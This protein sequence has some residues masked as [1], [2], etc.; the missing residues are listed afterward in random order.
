MSTLVIASNADDYQY[1]REH[2]LLL[3]IKASFN[4]D[5]IIWCDQEDCLKG[6]SQIVDY[7]LYFDSFKHLTYEQVRALAAASLTVDQVY[8]V[9]LKDD[10]LWLYE[11]GVI[12]DCILH[13]NGI[14]AAISKSIAFTNKIVQKGNTVMAIIVAIIFAVLLAS[15]ISATTQ[16]TVYAQPKQE[17]QQIEKEDNAR[18]PLFF[19]E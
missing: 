12:I 16:P 11:D 7:I 10:K 4:A 8:G 6:L 2:D 17:I 14:A 1:L 13:R 3:D 9:Q 19:V 15:Y 18:L 5:Y